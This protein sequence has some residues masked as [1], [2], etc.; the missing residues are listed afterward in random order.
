MVVGLSLCSVDLSA[1][2]MSGG[3]GDGGEMMMLALIVLRVIND[4]GSS[5]YDNADD[6]DCSDEDINCD[7]NDEDI[8]SDCY[9][10]NNSYDMYGD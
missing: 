4:N 5:D 9:Y 8:D 3:E 2:V 10:D 1:V 6:N 7:C